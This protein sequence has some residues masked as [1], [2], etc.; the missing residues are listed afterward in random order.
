MSV[1]SKIYK[2]FLNERHMRKVFQGRLK[3]HLS[4]VNIF[5]DRTTELQFKNWPELGKGLDIVTRETVKI[6]SVHSGSI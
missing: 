6:R 3:L 4:L 5:S 1:V 2:F